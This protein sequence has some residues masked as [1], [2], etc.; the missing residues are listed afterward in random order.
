MNRSVVA[1]SGEAPPLQRAITGAI[2]WPIAAS[3]VSQ[4]RGAVARIR[5]LS[6]SSIVSE[7]LVG[8]ALTGLYRLDPVGQVEALPSGLVE[9]GGL[10]RVVHLGASRQEPQVLVVRGADQGVVVFLVDLQHPV[11]ALGERDPAQS[12]GQEAHLQL[13]WLT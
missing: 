12:G 11:V 7:H 4:A 10:R 9:E 2:A 13:G 3:S 1:S 6:V 5:M 8:H